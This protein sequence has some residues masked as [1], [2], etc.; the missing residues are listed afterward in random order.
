MGDNDPIDACE[1]GTMVSLSLIIV[2]SI[3]LFIYLVIIFIT[4]NLLF[5]LFRQ[6]KPCMRQTWS[7]RHLCLLPKRLSCTP[8]PHCACLRLP[9][10]CPC[11]VGQFITECDYSNRG[12]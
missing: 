6:E 7:A 11:P 10:K 4:G 12:T 3:Y 5:S 9:E 1:I 8:H 2:N